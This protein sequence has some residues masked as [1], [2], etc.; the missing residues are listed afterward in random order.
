MIKQY[1]EQDGLFDFQLVAGG[2]ELLVSKGFES[3]REAGLWIRRLKSE[4][5]ASLADAPVTKLEDVV[6]SDIENALKMLAVE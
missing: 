2:R 4:G 3:G 6:E 5:I 1:T